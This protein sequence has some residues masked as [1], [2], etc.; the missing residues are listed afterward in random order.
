MILSHLHQRL[1][2]VGLAP[3]WLGQIDWGH[4][5]E[6]LQ[7][8]LACNADQVQGLAVQILK[9]LLCI[10]Y[11]GPADQHFWSHWAKQVCAAQPQ[12]SYHPKSSTRLVHLS[13]LQAERRLAGRCGCRPSTWPALVAESQGQAALTQLQH[14][15]S[16]SFAALLGL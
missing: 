13:I 9:H 10:K 5:V 8:K 11:A 7:E 12:C 4:L 15:I 16:Q 2:P 6:T 14:A 1:H 3:L